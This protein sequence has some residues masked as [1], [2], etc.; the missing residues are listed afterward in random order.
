MLCV[1]L[2]YELNRKNCG[3]LFTT[4]CKN[5]ATQIAVED[6]DCAAILVR[7]PGKFGLDCTDMAAVQRIFS[8]ELEVCNSDA[9][10][11]PPESTA[12][13]GKARGQETIVVW[14]IMGLC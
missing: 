3:T 9:L 5:R 11:V 8:A 2:L 14:M 1:D 6:E 7:G 4:S 10:E 13:S 12:E